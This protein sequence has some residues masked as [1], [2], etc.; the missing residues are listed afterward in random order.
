MDWSGRWNACQC[1]G[2]DLTCDR[3]SR[4]IDCVDIHICA[5]NFYH[6]WINV[7]RIFLKNN[8]SWNSTLYN[9]FEKLIARAVWSPTCFTHGCLDLH[10]ECICSYC[11]L[12]CSN[13]SKI[14]R[15]GSL[16]ILTNHISY[17]RSHWTFI[18][19]YYVRLNTTLRFQI[20][21][22]WKYSK[23]WLLI[24]D[25]INK[26]WACQCSR[27]NNTDRWWAVNI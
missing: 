16:R 27:A 15:S 4:W 20:R 22:V 2:C 24:I 19:V 23:Y 3:W 1:D 21:R 17:T 25:L 6:F 11:Q 10:V 9:Q 8:R 12:F 5:P 13:Y 18:W 14:N 7:F 26:G